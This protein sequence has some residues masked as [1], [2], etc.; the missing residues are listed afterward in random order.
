MHDCICKEV[1]RE[2]DGFIKYGCVVKLILVHASFNEK[3][4]ATHRGIC[5]RVYTL[6]MVSK[7]SIFKKLIFF[8]EVQHPSFVIVH[9]SITK[10]DMSGWF[11]VN[12]NPISDVG[13]FFKLEIHLAQNAQLG[14]GLV[15]DRHEVFLKGLLVGKIKV[16]DRSR[17]YITQLHGNFFQ[18][19]I[20]T[21]RKIFLSHNQFSPIP[22]AVLDIK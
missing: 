19:Q 18:D 20:H 16:I 17:N 7:H 6:Q 15:R 3:S 11:C 21:L 4:I 12:L 9:S 22:F 10:F 14:K 5:H 2:R 1:Y 13:C 8:R